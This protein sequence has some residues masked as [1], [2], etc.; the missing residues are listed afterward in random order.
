MKKVYL[1]LIAIFILG[2]FLRLMFLPQGAL[3]FGF[4]QARDA[5]TAGDILKGDLKIQGPSASTPGLFHGVLYFYLITPSYLVGQGD[6]IVTAVWLA[7]INM[8]TIVPIFILARLLFSAKVGFIAAFLFAIS[9]DATQYA[10]WMSNPAPAV[11]AT[12][13]FYLGLALY[14][15]N[16]KKMLGVVLT[17]LGLGLSTQF[18]IF[19]G[20]L[21]APLLIC[22][23]VFK[24]KPSLKH[25]LIFSGVFLVT[26]STMILSYAKFGPTFISGLSSLLEGKDPFGAWR[27]FSPTLLLYLNRFVEYF[28]RGLMPFNI[29]L[30]GLFAF[31]IT[32]SVVAWTAKQYPDRKKLIFLLILLFSHGLIIPFGGDYTPF[33]NAGLQTAVLIIVAYF[34]ITIYQKY[35][36]LAVLLLALM[37]FSSI[38]AILKYNPQGQTVF[39]IQRGLILRNELAAI[40]YT[41]GSSNGEPFSVNT[42]T[43]PLWIN[44]VWAYL[45]NWYGNKKYGY[46]PSYHGRDQT[47]NLGYLPGVSEKDKTF[48]LIIEPLAGIPEDFANQTIGHEDYFSKIV[49]TKEFGGI[50]VQKRELEMPFKQINFL[51]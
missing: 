10:I 36:A 31:V 12:S 11:L 44:T 17:A 43:S 25:I 21:F 34:L 27:Q 30:A 50:V 14:I 16:A 22:L 42:I 28:Y 2:L 39:A 13:I 47:G 35:R 51:K 29:G 7:I 5:Y 1:P 4:D 26:V 45:Y 18:E 48:Y 15:F 6:P 3:T 40:D 8:L 37:V 24:V 20:Y 49:E 46:T 33:I 9:L 38:N 32:S 41:Y 23:Y 19:L